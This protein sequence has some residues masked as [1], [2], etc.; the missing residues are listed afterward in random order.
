MSV[1]ED[2]YL[3]NNQLTGSIPPEVAGMEELRQLWITN[4]QFNGVLPGELGRSG[5]TAHPAAETATASWGAC[6]RDCGTWRLTTSPNWDLRT[7]RPVRWG[8]PQGSARTLVEGTY[9]L[10]W[11]AVTGRG[12]LRGPVHDGRGGRG[13]RDL[14]GPVGRHQRLP[15]LHPRGDPGLRRRLPVPGEGKRRRH[16]ARCPLGRRVGGLRADA[17]LSPGIH[18]CSPLYL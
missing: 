6:R 5:G 18:R 9:S 14:D 8:R 3:Y 10:T 13:D 2:L 11:N 7:V 15:D 17:Q 12:A 4:N 16:D 1:L